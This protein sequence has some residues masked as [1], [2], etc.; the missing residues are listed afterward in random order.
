[1][2]QSAEF[3]PYQ[4]IK[5]HLNIDK[6]CVLKASRVIVPV[7]LK[8]KVMQMLHSEYVGI[9]KTKNLARYYVWWHKID[10]NIENLVKSCEPCHLNRNDPEK[11]SS[12]SWQYPSKPWERIHIDFCGPFR[13]HMYLIVVDTYSKSPEVI[14]MSSS[15]S[16][17]ETIKVLISLFSRQGLPDKLVS[18]NGPQFTSDEFEEFMSNCGILHIKTAPYHPQT[19][20]EAERFIQT[21]KNFVKRADHDKNLN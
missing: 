7:K 14:R 5:D 17:S 20:G 1:M 18:D 15:T 6:E 21:F 2:P 9:S 11:H 3:L 12:H 16:T 13:N 4:R 10:E 19:N 8:D